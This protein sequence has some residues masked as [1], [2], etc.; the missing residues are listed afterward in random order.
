MEQMIYERPRE[1][2][3]NQ[4][5]GSLSI[6]E[7]FQLVISSGSSHVSGAQLANALEGLLFEDSLTYENV[8]RLRGMGEAKTC[9]V[10]AVV[11]L[12]KRIPQ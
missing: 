1:K 9:Q 4:G 10:L 6:A 11:E 2:L 8:I 7:L 12:A 5:L 3:R